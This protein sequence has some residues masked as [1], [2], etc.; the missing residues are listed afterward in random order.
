MSE[1]TD[2][3]VDQV[4]AGNGHLVDPPIIDLLY[5]EPEEQAYI[6]TFIPEPAVSRERTES[7]HIGDTSPDGKRIAVWLRELGRL[8]GL[9]GAV[10]KLFHRGA[11]DFGFYGD[12]ASEATLSDS[13]SSNA[14]TQQAYVALQDMAQ[15]AQIAFLLSRRPPANRLKTIQPRPIAVEL[16]DRQVLTGSAEGNNA[17]WLCVCGYRAPLLGTTRTGAGD[18][19]CPNC[20]RVYRVYPFPHRGQKV[21]G[22]KEVEPARATG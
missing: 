2:I 12:G 22:V 19:R 4:A 1:A 8:F 13:R 16:R 20:G 3:P 21:S 5:F 10:R 18:T 15:C 6:V 7:V 17:S 9:E 11:G 14:A